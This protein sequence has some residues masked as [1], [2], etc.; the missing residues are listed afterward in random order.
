MRNLKR[1]LSLGLTAAM[2]SGLMVMGSSAASYAD[3]TSEQNQEAIEVLQAVGIMVGDEN[4]NFNPDAQVTRNEMAVIMS[5]LMDYRVATYSGTSPFTDV[6]SW[7]EPYVAAC[8]TNG[9]TAGY[10]A[11]TYGGSDTVTTAQAA[12]MLMKALGYFQYASDFGSDWQLET[13]SQATKIDL[14]TDVDSGVREAMT[15]NDL[16]QLVLNTLKAGTVEA[17]DDTIKVTTDGAVVEA[18]SVTYNY[19]T[20]GRPYATAIDNLRTYTSNAGT[21]GSDGYIVELGEKLYNGD[22]KKDKAADDFGRPSNVWTYKS[23]EIGKY[24]DNAVTTWTT[25]VTEKDL[26]TAV[27]SAAYDNYTWTVYQNGYERYTD[28]NNHAARDAAIAHSKSSSERVLIADKGVLTQVFVD[29]DKEQVVLTMIETGVGEV[30]RVAEDGGQYEVTISL[31]TKV[32][33]GL[34]QAYTPDSTF[35]T[36][37]KFERG[38][39]VV[40]TASVSSGEIESMALAQTASGKVTAVKTADYV[41]LDGTQYSYNYSYTKTNGAAEYVIANGI[42]NLDDSAIDNPAIDKDATLY[43][44]TYGYVVAFTGATNT[45]EDYLYITEL[46]EVFSSEPSAKVVFYDGSKATIDVDKVNVGDKTYDATTTAGKN[47]SDGTYTIETGTIYKF[48]KGSSSYD[49][50]VVTQDEGTG[51]TIKKD[52]PTITTTGGTAAS[53]RTNNDTV[54]VDTVNNKAW[55]GYGNV[56]SKSGATI[57]VVYDNNVALIV[58]ISGNFTT[59]PDD[60]DYIILTGTGI[61]AVKDSNNKTVYRLTSAYD[62]NGNKLDNVYQT[63]STAPAVKGLYL[64]TNRDGNDYI[65]SMSLKTALVNNSFYTVSG[66]SATRYAT[67]AN[68]G[69]LVLNSGIDFGTPGYPNVKNTF[70]I[71]NDTTYIVVTQTSTGD[72]DKISV[73]SLSDIEDFDTAAGADNTDLTGVYVMTVD[74]ATDA[75]PV[76]ESVLVIVP[77]TGSTVNPTPPTTPTLSVT[78]RDNDS[79][80][81]F[82][83]PKFYT[84]GTSA[85][86]MTSDD[87]YA[88][89]VDAKCTNISATGST[90][91]FTKSN[92]VP[93]TGQTITPVQQIKITL[94]RTANTYVDVGATLAKGS[95]DAIKVGTSFE[96]TDHTYTAADEGKVFETGY[97]SITNGT[98]TSLAANFDVTYQVNSESAV[99]AAPTYAKDGD[100]IKVIATVKANFDVTDGYSSNAATLKS[101]NGAEITVNGDTNAAID[102]NTSGTV[103]FKTS[104][105]VEL[106]QGTTFTVELTVG[107]GS[108][109]LPDLTYKAAS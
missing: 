98:Y 48:T 70:A 17:D 27:G 67:S 7:A 33:N 22:L 81:N 29:D 57:D 90:W 107:S 3:V 31:K 10:S 97:R 34:R 102:S 50:E 86:T 71:N 35:T 11:T 12:L 8:W 105:N 51:A 80:N 61:E 37:Q 41:S 58:F 38:D 43:L 20:S 65:Q 30:S 45:P 24:A 6:P 85:A 84:G 19:V 36:E 56:S 64:I 18:G 15:R 76:A 52:N 55:T 59:T 46:G 21:G 40:Y 101:G 49:L 42:Y 66:A 92:G 14:F 23:S 83:H 44:D 96:T 94:N 9:I 1:A 32:N 2:I 5:N 16:A 4:G 68:A 74:D 69:L 77:Y 25:K 79:A 73:G 93:V 39:I 108:V 60:D 88:M 78:V 75:A 106:S 109:T 13:V 91:N 104:G 72:V 53:V 89:L 100:V 62:I 103:T 87:I 26:Y 28:G 54:Y 63:G 47:G 99:S 95:Y 82:A